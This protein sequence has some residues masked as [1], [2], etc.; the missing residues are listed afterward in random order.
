ME[1]K[2]KGELTAKV[3]GRHYQRIRKA[4]PY[5]LSGPAMI[6]MLVFTFLPMLYLIYLSFCSYD[7]ISPISWVGIANYARLFLVEDSFWNALWNTVVYTAAIV[8]FMILFALMLSCW[9]QEDSKLDAFAQ[10]M[11]FLPHLCSGVAIS[12]VFKWLMDDEGLLNA[13]LNFFRLPGLQWLNSSSTAM[14][15]VIIVSLWKNM[16]YYGL[17]LLASLKAIPTELGEAAALD[18]AGP[19]RKFFKITLPMLSPQLFFLVIT[20]TIG[21]FKVFDSI[22]MLTEGG[23]G[24]S[25][26]VLVFWIYRKAF[27]GTINVGLASAAGVVLMVILMFL[28][29]FYFKAL[30]KK[31]HYQ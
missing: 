26:D 4:M 10:R 1:R 2:K 16:G 25:T 9:L 8:V 3:K 11:M 14:L 19:V 29:M 12:L 24:N 27:T 30:N 6:L 17:I 15:S 23:P 7:L 22:R 28:T 5:I 20:I 18:N 13:V 21:S 31:V